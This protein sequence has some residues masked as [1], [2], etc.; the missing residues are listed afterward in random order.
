MKDV[1]KRFLVNLSPQGGAILPFLYLNEIKRETSLMMAH[2]THT[3]MPPC[4]QS[5]VDAHLLV[6][7]YP[8]YFLSTA[9]LTT[10]L[11]WDF[12]IVASYFFLQIFFEY[13]I[14][15]KILFISTIWKVKF[16]WKFCVELY[17]SNLAG[18][19]EWRCFW[20][21][22]KEDPPIYQ[23]INLVKNSFALMMMGRV[24]KAC[25]NFVESASWA[26]WCIP[27]IHTLPRWDTPRFFDNFSARVILFAHFS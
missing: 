23:V 24:P 4:S 8:R 15:L 10:Q 11:D 14:Q 6:C 17:L 20:P 3:S 1:V 26:P 16:N 21:H 7:W 22:K 13:S 12:A 18:T 19:R 5:K 2:K 27:Y 9:A 25:N